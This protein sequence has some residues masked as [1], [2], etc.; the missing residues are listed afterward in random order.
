M[1]KPISISLVSDVRDFIRGTKDAEK[2]LEDVGTSLDDLAKDAKDS[3]KAAGSAL[4]HGL[5]DGIKDA[6]KSTDKLERSFKDLADVAKRESNKAGDA[7]GKNIHDGTRKAEGGM[8]DLKDEAKQTARES[9]ASFG[10]VED[11]LDAVQELA[12]NAFVGMGPAGMA[13]GL[14]GAIG[15][16]L[17]ASALQDSAE[18]ATEAKER[19]GD[20]A[21]ELYDAGGDISRI[22]IGAKMRE[23]SGQISD[24]KEWWEIWQEGVV[25]NL[26]QVR[27]AA[28]LTGADAADMFRAMSGYDAEAAKEAL[29]DVNR[30]IAETQDIVNS[31]D[32]NT[33]ENFFGVSEADNHKQAL[34][35]VRDQLERVTDQ[36]GEAQ[37][38]QELMAEATA[39]ET[40]QAEAAEAAEQRRADAIAAVD[41]AYDNAAGAVTDYID[42]E[43]GLFDVGAYIEAMETKEQA[44]RDYQQTLAESALTDDAKAFLNSQ[45][46]DAAAQFLAGYKDATPA[47]QA[48]LNRIWSE[49]GRENSGQYMSELR[50]GVGGEIPGPT[51][52]ARVDDS[53]VDAARNRW[54]NSVVSIPVTAKVMGSGG[55]FNIP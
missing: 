17:V 31:Q 19:V 6:S 39:R 36:T 48:E 50:R 20:L 32:N 9:A 14:V 24:N 33:W 34:I 41:D 53:A 18:K 26:D 28:A 23:W 13:A 43:S 10:S 12:A 22:D 38:A 40:A 3:G 7:I 2:A 35:G 29:E 21:V 4:E 37:A 30:Q 49:T 52:V 47:Q 55:R 5:E 44:L 45:G 1:A 25:S 46:V 27:D 51:V 15:I 11:A 42:K 8:D 16:G 54:A